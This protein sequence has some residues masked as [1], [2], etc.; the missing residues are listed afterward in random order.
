MT[1]AVFLFPLPLIY[2][3]LYRNPKN[4][5]NHKTI[6]LYIQTLNKEGTGFLAGTTE[7]NEPFSLG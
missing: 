2:M 3:I 1:F 4:D 5:F 6:Y 7:G